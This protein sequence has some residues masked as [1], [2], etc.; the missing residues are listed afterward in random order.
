M[1]RRRA[2]VGLRRRWEAQG[3]LLPRRIMASEATPP[4]SSH[5]PEPAPLADAKA[6]A[7]PVA[8]PAD[9]ER[10]PEGGVEGAVGAW[11]GVV[12]APCVEEGSADAC[13]PRST[14]N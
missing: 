7:A 5:T 11:A 2:E 14:R 13:E 9:E 12:G 3:D 8:K 10:P 1:A 4:N 6:P